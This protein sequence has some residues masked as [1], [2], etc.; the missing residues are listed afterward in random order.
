MTT[1]HIQ[2]P[3]EQAITTSAWTAVA[4]GTAQSCSEFK[5]HSRGK[6]SWKISDDSAGATHF[7]VWNGDAIGFS[8]RAP[9]TATTGAVMFYAQALSVNDT[10]EM[11]ITK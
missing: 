3:I 2:K 1:G 5:V 4:L 8:L 7:T 10:L 9:K 6:N 11:I